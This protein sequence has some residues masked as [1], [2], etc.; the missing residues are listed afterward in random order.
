LSKSHV[1][2]SAVAALILLVGTLLGVSAA[3]ATPAQANDGCPTPY[4][5]MGIHVGGDYLDDYGGGSGTYVHTYPHTGSPNQTWCP[6]FANEG[7]IY[8]HP[9]NNQG[10]C[11]DAHTDNPGQQI[12]VY[13]CNGTAP[14]R[15]CWDS[16]INGYM[17]RSTNSARALRDNGTYNIVTIVGPGS[18][19]NH[20][21]SSG[22]GGTTQNC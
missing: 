6:Q 16:S 7:G 14:Q 15:W 22:P 11:L 5:P 9:M 19:A 12:W 17:V 4:F 1:A 18:G 2:V 8:L 21:A 13:T 20:W 3:T 10:L